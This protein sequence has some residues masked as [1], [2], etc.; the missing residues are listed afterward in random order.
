[1][2]CISNVHSQVDPLQ[3]INNTSLSFFSFQV[4]QGFQ[5]LRQHIPDGYRMKKM[6]KVDTL[7]C[8]L[9]YIRTLERVLQESESE[10]DPSASASTCP[11]SSPSSGDNVEDNNK[12]SSMS[13]SS[14][15]DE[16]YVLQAFGSEEDKSSICFSD[17]NNDENKAVDVK[18]EVEVMIIERE[19]GG[20]FNSHSII[21]DQ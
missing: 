4:N 8:A 14:E 9:R 11:S 6:S 3:R 19:D 21:G 2:K 5:T 15:D 1:M 18:E 7:R 20:D 13:L 17:E 12:A 16:Y 10:S